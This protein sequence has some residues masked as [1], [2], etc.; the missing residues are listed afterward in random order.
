MLD[1][2]SFCMSER[3]IEQE[4]NMTQADVDPSHMSLVDASMHKS[5]NCGENMRG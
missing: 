5:T 1:V 2:A 3:E 4:P